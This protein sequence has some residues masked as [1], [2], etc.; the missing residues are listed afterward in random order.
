MSWLVVVTYYYGMFTGL[1]MKSDKDAKYVM[2]D[3]QKLVK[4]AII[5]IFWQI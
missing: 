4:I 1:K 3:D 2:Y 5:A